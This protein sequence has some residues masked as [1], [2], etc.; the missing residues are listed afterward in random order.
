MTRIGLA[1]VGAWGKKWLHTIC[2]DG[3]RTGD[4][5][6]VIVLRKNPGVMSDFDST[7]NMELFLN[8]S[9]LVIVATPTETHFDIVSAALQAGKR[10]LCEKPLAED[11]FDV[12]NLFDLAKPGQLWVAYPHLWHPDVEQMARQPG[13]EY[14]YEVTF[15]GPT[16]R[17]P[18]IDWGVHAIS[19]G[20]YLRGDADVE[21]WAVSKDRTRAQVSLLDRRGWGRAWCE[22]GASPA[23]R[24]RIAMKSPGRA[25]YTGDPCQPS[26]MQRMLRAFVDDVQD[27]RAESSLT[28][29]TH[30]ILEEVGTPH[31][32]DP[33][34]RCAF[35]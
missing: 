9:D 3:R 25:F 28:L 8:E 5:S 17:E 10:V 18:L 19:A 2:P 30:Q 21:K 22:F 33:G 26:T 13:A 27:P 23:K 34:G 31:T 11:L 7:E 1:G 16:P 24:V 14:E 35:Y 20:L 29:R 32:S 12:I 15:C 6:G 4:Y